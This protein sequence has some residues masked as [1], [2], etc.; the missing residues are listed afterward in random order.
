MKKVCL[1]S[2]SSPEFLG[3]ISLFQ[4][5]FIDYAEKSNLGLDFTWIYPGNKNRVYNLGSLN[6]VELE[7]TNIPF[8]KELNFAKKSKKYLKENIF[9]IINTHADWGA[10]LKNYSKKSNQKIIHTYHGASVPYL[11]IQIKQFFFLKRLFLQPVIW[12]SYYLE[13]IP[14]KRADK[15]ICVSEKVKRDLEKLYGKR[16]SISVIRT[17]V[18]TKKFKSSPKDKSRKELGLNQNKIYGLYSGRGGYWIKG[19]DR[20]VNISKEIYKENKNFRLIVIGA[21]KNKCARY[22]E[23]PFII[24]KDVVARKNLQKYYSVCDFFFAL[25]RYEG[26]APT[27]AVGEAMASGC[28]IIFS[29]DSKQEIIENNKNG[30]VINTFGKESANRIFGIL[31]NKRKLKDIKASAIEGIKKFGLNEWGKKYFRIVGFK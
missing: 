30:L 9:D 1:I 4:K 7:T 26:G 22:L 28:L 24:H 21:A 19:L 3:G 14:Y 23:E 31:K 20:A 5:N 16:Q 25:S 10:G 15:I 18:D 29:K 11:K 12:I 8:L 6:C 2:G 17:G 27:L 13:K